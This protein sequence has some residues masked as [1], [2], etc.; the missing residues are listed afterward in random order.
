MPLPDQDESRSHE[1]KPWP[2]QVVKS[3]YKRT[4]VVENNGSV[5]YHLRRE[6]REGTRILRQLRERGK[7]GMHR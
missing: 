2:W 4:E 3:E 1:L 5:L 7:W 6:K